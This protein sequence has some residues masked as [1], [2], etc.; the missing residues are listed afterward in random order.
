MRLEWAPLAI[1]DRE[2]IFDY[3]APE[4]LDAALALDELLERKA[5][6][7]SAHPEAG[8]VGRVRGTR[9]LVAHR[10]YVLVYDTDPDRVRILR[11]LHTSRQWPPSRLATKARTRE[12]RV[13]SAKPRRARGK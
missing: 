5:A 1:A 2:S 9:E 12:K 10:H 3:I 13:K 8:H 11:V 7:L 6:L 4:N